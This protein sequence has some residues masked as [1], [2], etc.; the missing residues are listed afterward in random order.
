M[1]RDQLER[2][3]IRDPRVLSAFQAVDRE[4]FLPEHLSDKAYEDRALPIGLG[5]TISQPYM[6]ALMTQALQITPDSRVLEVG[7]GS[8]YQTAILSYLARD[9]VT[10]ERLESISENARDT[11]DSLGRTNVSC[12][13]GDG[14]I[15]LPAKGSFD[16]IIVTAGAP[17]IPVPL[18]EQLATP[19]I[20]VV[21]VGSRDHQTL[22]RVLKT[23]EGIQKEDLGGCVFVPLVGQA[24]YAE[25]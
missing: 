25:E 7:T 22:I 19:G 6:V 12:I 8:G 15:G 9:V 1:V 21:P 5:Q 10:V 20:L 4:R 24:G 17:N 16:R 11:L 13:V 14:S 3:G 18:V 23:K 2:R